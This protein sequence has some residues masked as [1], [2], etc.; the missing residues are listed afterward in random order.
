MK[1]YNFYKFSAVLYVMT[2]LFLASIA[3]QV[4][5]SQ[6]QSVAA[7]QI[8]SPAQI[9]TDVVL[10]QETYDRLHPGYTRYTD[11]S[12]LDA[13]WQVIVEQAEKQN[14]LALG[15]FYLQVQKTLSLIRCDHTKANLPKTMN[16]ER[17]S[18][19]VYLPFRWEWIENRAFIT[20]SDPSTPFKVNDEILFIDGQPIAE[21]VKQVMPYIPYD[22]L[23]EWSRASG[24]AASLEFK[25]GAV[26][27]F[28]AL[29]WD[30]KPQVNIK[31]KSLD[32][33][34]QEHLVTRIN[35][36]QW[37]A[38]ADESLS[39]QNFKDA[40]KLERI[41]DNIAYLRIDTFVNYRQPVEPEDIYA[42]VFKAIKQEN[43]QV[44][45]LDLRNNGGGSTDASHG[46]LANLISQPR[47]AK[48]DM[49]AKT[50]DM[51]GIRQHLWTWDK[52]ALD[53]YRIAF[54][55]NDDNTYSLR[56][57]LTDDLDTIKPAKYA[58]N[59]KIIALT[60]HNNSSGSTNLLT[61]IQ[62]AG[63]ATLVGEKTGG[64]A[65]GPTAG[66][67][68]TLTLPESKITTRVPYFQ[69][70]NNVERFENGMGV[71]PDIEVRRSAEDYLDGKDGA[72]SAAIKLASAR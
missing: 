43:R 27:H 37:T 50:L 38:L 21:L 9:R 70:S 18:M 20:Q 22:G 68:F 13:E 53:P 2:V 72:L 24:I 10:L 8:F 34:I 61:N 35:Y 4:N 54:S 6:N 67:L 16:A 42:P 31:V 48:T 26:D 29:L 59:G 55:K 3:S 36:K 62:A 64:S 69:Y 28:G 66:L 11:K 46:L 14:G 56:S 25:G 63:S 52:R 15:D 71:I 30:I 49:R 39:G 45:I 40:V 1:H 60:S 23:T 32:V 51:D 33:E 57:W 65:Q 19:P 5:A 12:V 17:D 47:Q 41:G 58:F 7:K 44:L